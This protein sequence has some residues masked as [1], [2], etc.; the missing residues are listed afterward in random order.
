M[1]FYKAN[2]PS[3]DFTRQNKGLKH[4]KSS[5]PSNRRR[6]PDRGSSHNTLFENNDDKAFKN[7]EIKLESD[8]NP[9]LKSFIY[10]IK[11]F[12]LNDSK[13][14]YFIN[15]LNFKKNVEDSKTEGGYLAVFNTVIRIQRAYK[16]A[17]F[18]VI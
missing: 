14:S 15:S 18:I 8:P 11:N 1:T 17:G 16:A 9:E 4:I 6:K 7:V 13:S 12:D 10:I 5:R 3:K 2:R